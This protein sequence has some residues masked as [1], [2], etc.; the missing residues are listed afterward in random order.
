MI[1][2]YIDI[3]IRNKIDRICGYFLNGGIT[4]PLLVI[5]QITYLLLIKVLDENKVRN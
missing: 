2:G 1:W 5:E 3:D 4:N